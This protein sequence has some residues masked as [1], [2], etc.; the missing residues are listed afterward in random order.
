MAIARNTTRAFFIFSL[1][2]RYSGKDFRT[3]FRH[4]GP[5][6]GRDVHRNA[7]QSK[8]IVLDVRLFRLCFILHRN[9]FVK[10]RFRRRIVAILSKKMLVISRRS[11]II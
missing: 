2:V 5:A 6:A 10:L 3:F 7:T 8:Q 4:G 9:C 11:V 1:L